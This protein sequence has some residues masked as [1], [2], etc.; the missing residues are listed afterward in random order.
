MSFPSFTPIQLD[1]LMSS[2]ES[3]TSKLGPELAS[4]LG[5]SAK[6]IKSVGGFEFAGDSLIVQ[7]ADE[8]DLV[9]AKADIKALVS[10][11][12][13]R[14]GDLVY[15]VCHSISDERGFGVSDS[16]RYCF[17]VE[18]SQGVWKMLPS[19]LDLNIPLYSC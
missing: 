2:A 9:H 10:G 16:L 17:Q 3:L 14:K 1:S 15:A 13:A 18:H 6:E 11:D 8:V 19:D 4:A 12:G 5:L 7:I